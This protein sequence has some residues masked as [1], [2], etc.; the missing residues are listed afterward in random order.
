MRLLR[1]VRLLLPNWTL[2]Y[3]VPRLLFLVRHQLLLGLLQLLLIYRLGVV[4]ASL[5]H[6]FKDS[7]ASVMFFVDHFTHFLHKL[8]VIGVTGHVVVKHSHMLDGQQSG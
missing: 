1:R 2:R 7:Y 8:R 5:S 3:R 4:P 6:G